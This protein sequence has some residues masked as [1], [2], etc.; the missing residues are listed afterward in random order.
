MIQFSLPEDRMR[1][2]V[3]AGRL[4]LL[5]STDPLPDEVFEL[6]TKKRKSLVS[7]LKDFRRSQISKQSWNRHRWKYLR[8]IKKFHK[9]V[10]GKKLHRSM[11][12]FLATRIFHPDRLSHLSSLKA[13]S[14]KA[15]SSLKTH[16]Y[17]IGQYYMPL[18][19]D[20]E[21]NLFLDYSIPKLVSVEQKLFEDIW[22]QINS[23][24]MELLFRLT[25][26]RD[27]V[28]ALDSLIGPKASEAWTSYLDVSEDILDQTNYLTYR[29]ALAQEPYVSDSELSESTTDI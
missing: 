5:E 18:E 27:L 23:D 28:K 13:E 15:V 3:D 10:D 22:D 4:D 8:G 25:D 19:E 2:L 14:L 26:S 21:Y 29:A 9:S 17:L 24:E 16:L 20:V 12:R 6:F 7:G 1:F 11:G